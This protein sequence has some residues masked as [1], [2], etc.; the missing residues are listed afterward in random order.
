MYCGKNKTAC[1]TRRQTAQAFLILLQEEPYARISITQLCQ[2]AGISRQT[3]YNLFQS[4]ENVLV[5]TLEEDC[6]YTH[7]E[8]Q[9]DDEEMLTDLADGFSHYIISHADVIRTLVENDMTHIIRSMLYEGF[10]ENEC[11]ADRFGRAYWD[12]AANFTAGGLTG[13]AESYVRDGCSMAQEKLARIIFALLSG[14]NF[15]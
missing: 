12:Y 3:F 9:T 4:K 5:Y 2:A 1:A 13:I 11:M 8:S 6:C 7:P 15:I 10:M 14:D